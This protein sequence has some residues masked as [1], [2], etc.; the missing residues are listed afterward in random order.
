MF[1]SSLDPFLFS[2]WDSGDVS[3]RPRVVGPQVTEALSLFPK[4]PVPQIT[5]HL[6]F[7]L[8]LTDLLMRGPIRGLFYLRYCILGFKSFHSFL[9][10]RLFLCSGCHS[11]LPFYFSLVKCSCNTYVRAINDP[12]DLGCFRVDT[13]WLFSFEKE[14]HFPGVFWGEGV[15][16]VTLIVSWLF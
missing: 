10:H 2:S 14:S 8:R 3:V 9:F 1:F 12:S 15:C 4:L 5:T 7:N 6:W 16:Q 13:C 11:F